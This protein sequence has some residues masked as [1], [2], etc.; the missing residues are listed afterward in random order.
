MQSLRQFRIFLRVL[1]EHFR[2]LCARFTPALADSILEVFPHA[3]RHQKLG[4]LGP[5]IEFLREPHFFFAEGLSVRRIRVLLVR[6]SIANMTVH[7]DQGGTIRRL[8]E[9]FKGPRQHRQ[10]VRIGNARDIPAIA[11]KSRGYVFAE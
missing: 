9:G 10:I 11:D 7:D 6:R 8:L 3:F 1:R 4:I 2:P 5:A